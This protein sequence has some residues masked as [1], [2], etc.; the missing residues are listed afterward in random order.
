MSIIKD[1]IRLA[2]LSPE[3]ISEFRPPQ[4]KQAIIICFF[5]VPGAGK[6]TVAQSFVNRYK[7]N[8]VYFFQINPDIIFEKLHINHEGATKADEEKV[9]C[10]LLQQVDFITKNNLC[11][12]I[13]GSLFTPSHLPQ[14]E[15]PI[16]EQMLQICQKNNASTH[17]YLVGISTKTKD[18]HNRTELR[19][20]LTQGHQVPI[21]NL[22]QNVDHFFMNASKAM[23]YANGVQAIFDNSFKSPNLVYIKNHKRVLI[24]QLSPKSW[25]YK[26]MN[27]S[28]FVVADDFF[29]QKKSLDRD[30]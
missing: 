11:A 4:M 27:P 15:P 28:S 8:G 1:L 19:A 25:V 23:S 10:L 20:K 21:Q 24:P 30:K 26:I 14:N 17:V 5:G 13:E 16:W 22:E 18:Y 6:T 9:N 29:K 12:T 2:L 7:S 3:E